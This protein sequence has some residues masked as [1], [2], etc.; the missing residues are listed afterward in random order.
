MK[1]LID[2]NVIL[3]MVLK[4]KNCDVSMEL[5]RKIRSFGAD[6]YITASV[7]TDL[8]YIIRKETHHIGQTYTVLENIFKLTAVLPVTERD[9]SDAF[10]RRWKDFE[11]CVQD[12]SGKNN[13]VDYI[14]TWNQ[15]DY[16]D[17]LLP[18]LSP[19]ACIEMIDHMQENGWNYIT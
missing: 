1:L 2:T 13:G 9:I 12:T 7:V 6:A 8:F 17:A 10:R 15:K 3:D 4:R 16:A 5:F 19:T 18:V 11:D 14:V